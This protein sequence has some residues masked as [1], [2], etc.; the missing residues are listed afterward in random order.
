M[1]KTSTS[2]LFK[3]HLSVYLCCCCYP[4]SELHT[5]LH[6]WSMRS[7]S[8]VTATCRNLTC[9]AAD[10]P[11]KWYKFDDGEVSECK[12]DDDEEMKSQC[13]GGD[14]VGEVFDHMLK[15]SVSCLY[16]SFCMWQIQTYKKLSVLTA[17]DLSFTLLNINELERL[18]QSMT[19]YSPSLLPFGYT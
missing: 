19:E 1:A 2:T 16:M 17:T 3:V 5:I 12:M 8:F 14:Y 15:R 4:A 6:I 9:S 7:C 13:F 11:A 18:L 10:E